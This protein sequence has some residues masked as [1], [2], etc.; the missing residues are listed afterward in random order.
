M[1]RVFLVVGRRISLQ[2]RLRGGGRGIRTPGTVS[3]I[4]FKV[5]K[6]CPQQVPAI[7]IR[8][9]SSAQSLAGIVFQGEDL[10]AIEGI[11]CANTEPTEWSAQFKTIRD[12]V[13][14]RPA[15]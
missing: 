3:G 12:K 11:C 5:S 9:P 7:T 10:Q 6:G 15:L 8:H 14:P 2:S 1:F 4:V 13:G